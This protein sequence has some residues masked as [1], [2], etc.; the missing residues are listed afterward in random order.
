MGIFSAPS[1]SSS[2]AREKADIAAAEAASREREREAAR[3]S[4]LAASRVEDQLAQARDSLPNPWAQGK[5]SSSAASSGTP[6]RA[7]LLTRQCVSIVHKNTGGVS[8]GLWRAV[9]G[10]GFP[11]QVIHCLYDDARQPK[12]GLKSEVGWGVTDT[13]PA[14]AFHYI[15]SALPPASTKVWYFACDMRKGLVP[16]ARRRDGSALRHGRPA[17]FL[18]GFDSD[19]ASPTCGP[20]KRAAFSARDTVGTA[21]AWMQAL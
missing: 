1:S 20:R 14:G 8:E 11:V 19:G 15:P 3:A 12:C 2:A 16:E 6:N 7:P 10:C 5:D 13:I 9:N 17:G 21:Q 4:A 18:A